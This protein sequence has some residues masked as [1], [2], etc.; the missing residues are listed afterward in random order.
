MAS[1]SDPKPGLHYRKIWLS[2][3][4]GLIALVV[5]LSVTSSPPQI[6]IDI[7][8]LDK[9]EHFFAY[10]VLMGWF[11]Q[12]YHQTRV[13]I[14]WFAAFVAMG[15]SLEII[16]GLG[17]VRYFEYADMAANTT[18]ALIGWLLTRGGGG[19]L[20]SWFEQRLPA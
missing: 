19:H 14:G 8:F 3:G 20:L 12:L 17:G 5:F 18:G 13:R 16:Q 2:I 4:W 9:L 15:I 1:D 10:S 6:D 7:A 11:G